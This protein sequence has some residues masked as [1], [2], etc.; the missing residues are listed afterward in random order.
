VTGVS[1]GELVVKDVN[2]T[3]VGNGDRVR[4]MAT[5]QPTPGS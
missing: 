4:P 1:P 3:T 5:A 2:D